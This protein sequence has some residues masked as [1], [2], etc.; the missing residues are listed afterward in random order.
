MSEYKQDTLTVTVQE[1]AYTPSG[2]TSAPEPGIPVNLNLRRNADLSQSDSEASRLYGSRSTD[3]NG[4]AVFSLTGSFTITKITEDSGNPDNSD[5]FLL[6]VTTGG[7][8]QLL[9]IRSGGTVKIS[10]IPY[11]RDWSVAEDEDWAWKYSGTV[12]LPQGQITSYNDLFSV[13]VTNI[14][15]G[16]H[17]FNGAAYAHNIF[18]KGASGVNLLSAYT[19]TGENAGYDRY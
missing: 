16:A 15:T 2:A 1:N 10:Q 17:W 9:P 3:S 5:T 18:G 11:G 4:S 6:R 8:T 7:S 13:T 12:S 19:Y 14:G